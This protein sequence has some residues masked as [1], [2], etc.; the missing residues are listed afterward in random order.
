MKTLYLKLILL[1]LIPI[2]CIAQ[3]P[4][5]FVEPNEIS[6]KGVFRTEEIKSENSKKQIRIDH[7]KL[8]AEDEKENGTGLPVRFGKAVD[9]DYNLENSGEWQEI[10]NAR[11]WKMQ[12]TS[13]EA[14]SLNLI[15][16]KLFIPGRGQLYIY[17]EQRTVIYGPVTSKDLTRSGKFSTDVISGESIILELLEPKEHFSR[18]VL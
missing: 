12:I 7:Q 2:T 9:V 14:L 10:G 17:N 8:L 18:S 1:V 3:I 13:K 6:E 15:F 5:R 16:K 4:T 11:V